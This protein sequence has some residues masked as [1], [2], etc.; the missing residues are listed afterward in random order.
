MLSPSP[1]LLRKRAKTGTA[2]TGTDYLFQ[3][4]RDSVKRGKRGLSPFSRRPR[5]PAVFPQG[6]RIRRSDECLGVHGA[7]LKGLNV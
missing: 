2:K 1:S 5:F 4:E 3:H 7:L 6:H